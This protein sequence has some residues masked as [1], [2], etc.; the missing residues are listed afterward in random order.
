MSE[1]KRSRLYATV[2]YPD[3]APE[4]WVDKLKET[5]VA[6]YISPLHKDDENPDGT[7]KKPHYHVLICY[8]GV[9]SI[10]QFDKLRETFGGVGHEVVQSKRGYARYLCHLD[11]PEKA[12]YNPAE[13]VSLGGE[14]YTELIRS[15]ADEVTAIGEMMDFID[16]NEIIYYSEFVRYCRTERRDWFELIATKCAYT[17][18][19][20]IKGLRFE[21][22]DKARHRLK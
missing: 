10:E 18:S 11:S 14:S 8:D 7:P 2:V 1:K 6:G 21:L 13:V 5:H 20:Y 22:E 16:Q 19:T 12:Q 15:S 17:I 3:S 4:G 9:K